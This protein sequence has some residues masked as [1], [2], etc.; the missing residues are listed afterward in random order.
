MRRVCLLEEYLTVK[1]IGSCCSTGWYFLGCF[2]VGLVRC[3]RNCSGV[4]FINDFTKGYADVGLFANYCQFVAW[5]GRSCLA[6]FVLLHHFVAPCLLVPHGCS[7]LCF[8]RSFL[9]TRITTWFFAALESAE[10]WMVI[11]MGLVV[12]DIVEGRHD[13]KTPSWTTDA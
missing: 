13:P 3:A 6:A 10:G 1:D 7:G 11:R 8:P 2:D 4:V 5:Q 9:I 12:G